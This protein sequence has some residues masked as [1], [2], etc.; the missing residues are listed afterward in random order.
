VQLTYLIEKGAFVFDKVSKTFSV[1]FEKAKQGVV[2]LSK[3]IM[4]IQAEG[5]KPRAAKLMQEYGV[6]TP[7]VAE[8]MQAI[9]TRGIPVDIFPR[10]ETAENIVA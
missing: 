9:E 6:L 10:Y 5:D 4:T 8:L 3:D 2:E 7:E 1:D